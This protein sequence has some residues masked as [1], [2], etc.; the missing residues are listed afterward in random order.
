MQIKKTVEILF[1]LGLF[2]FPFNQYE[3]IPALGEFSSEAAVVFFIPAFF[4][5]MAYSYFTKKIYFPI[6]NKLYGVILGLLIWCIFSFVFNFHDILFY[7]FK[8]TKGVSR[9]VRQFFS[10]ILSVV[11]FFQVYWFVLKDKNEIQILLLVRKVF[12]TSLVVVSVYGVIEIMISFFGI[13]FLIPIIDF[14]SY[15]PF[16]EPR[17]HIEGRISSVAYEP[18]FLAIYLITIAG[19]MFSYIITHKGYKKYIPSILIIILTFFSGSRTALIVVAFQFILFLFLI[20]KYFNKREIAQNFIKVSLILLVLIGIISGNKFYNAINEKIE[21]LDFIGNLKSNVSNKSRLGIQYTSL[22]IFSENP[23]FGVGFGQ[24]AYEA[25]G[26]YPYWSTIN[27]YEFKIFYNNKKEKSFP[28]GYNVYTR[29]LAEIGLIG[30]L[31]FIYLQII[32]LKE[33]K[34]LIKF[35]NQNIKILG[36]AIYISLIGLFINWLQIDSFRI[37]GVWVSLA[38]L[39]ITSKIKNEQNNHSNTALQ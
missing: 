6:K 39:I 16:L 31:I 33:A 30:F 25:R 29:I 18:P 2:F 10:L 23:I 7:N 24:Q 27:N 5:I 8:Q 15:L 19:W 14:F 20:A 38:I 13:S 37:Y 36:L 17:L 26:R 21:S 12:K 32:M 1:I 9:F 11:I 28:P 34:R 22:I 35:H 3:G 4:L